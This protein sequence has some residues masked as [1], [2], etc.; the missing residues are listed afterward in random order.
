MTTVKVKFRTSSVPGR[1]GVLYFQLIHN[2]KVKLITTRFRLLPSEWDHRTASVLIRTPDSKRA[3]YLQNIKQGIESERSA[4]ENLVLLFQKQTEYS[5]C[6]MV[7]SYKTQALNG[8]LIPFMEYQISKLKEVG[9]NKTAAIY[10]TTL[11]SFTCFR[12]CQDILFDKVDG[13]LIKLYETDLKVRGVKKNSISCYMR[14]LRSVYNKAVGCGL[15]IQRHP[16]Q[17]VYTGIDRTAKRA[18]NEEVIIRLQELDLSKKD[19]LSQARDLF[20]LSFYTRGMSFVDMAKLKKENIKDNRLT[21]RRSKTG[22]LLSIKMESC[23][24]AIIDKYSSQTKDTDYLLPIADKTLAYDSALRKHN[25]RLT[26]L[27]KLLNLSN[28]LSSYV[29]RHSWATLAASKGVPIQIISEGMGHESEK[30]TRIY[31]A[32]LDQSLLDKANAA[33][34]SLGK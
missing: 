34:M 24:L 3:D 6:A 12:N 20:M 7:D 23:I 27:S 14:I 19:C 31:L 13:N 22:Q 21:Y 11:K 8:Y 5:L 26:V 9:Q 16:F 33:I 10:I 17:N 18:V 2:R 30:T 15:T 1:E 32:S 25:K 4:I 28:P 29:S